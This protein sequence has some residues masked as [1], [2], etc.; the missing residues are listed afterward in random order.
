MNY[1]TTNQLMAHLRANGIA[2]SGS[3]QKRELELIGYYH[4]YKGYRFFKHKND[5]FVLKNFGELKAIVEFDMGMKTLF[6]APLMQLETAL[7]SYV[8]QLVIEEA[9]SS[10]FND[11]FKRLIL[12][13]GKDKKQSDM[14]QRLRLRDSINQAVTLHYNDSQIVPHFIEKGQDIPLWGIL[15]V[16]DLGTFGHMLKF[17]KP[18]IK[19]KVSLK[20]G[21]RKADS[22]GGKIS[23]DTIFVLK[24]LR[25]AVAHNNPIFDARFHTT[26][27]T[28]NNLRNSLIRSTGIENITFLTIVDF[29]ILIVFLML[30]MGYTKTSTRKLILDFKRNCI[31]LGNSVDASIYHKIVHTDVIRKINALE[32]FIKGYHA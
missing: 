1:Q 26:E 8:G 4:G 16:I 2:I 28:A 25:N 9:R 3:R 32:G 27:S 12:P 19:E 15:E 29:L 13:C 17:L 11:I 18:E 24:G 20:M 6:Y 7:H 14:H 5:C 21:F 22:T 23:C 31:I 30:S 10:D